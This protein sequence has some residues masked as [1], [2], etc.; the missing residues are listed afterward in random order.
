MS[1]KSSGAGP[2]PDPRGRS[3]SP[4]AS[5]T[6]VGADS[7]HSRRGG[8]GLSGS[9]FHKS[10][11]GSQAWWSVGEF[12]RPGLTHQSVGLT[13]SPDHDDTWDLSDSLADLFKEVNRRE[14]DAGASTS[15]ASNPS[16]GPRQH[17]GQ[18]AGQSRD[19]DDTKHVDVA[20]WIAD[21]TSHGFI[22]VFNSDTD[23]HS[24]LFPCT[25][26]TTAQKICMQIGMPSNSLHVQLNGDIIRRMEP[27]DCPLAVQNEYLAS[28]GYS[29][30]RRIQEEGSTEELSYLVKFYSGKDD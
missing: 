15:D 21:D 30:L 1:V 22:R 27:F 7:F 19:R 24:R 29:D 13:L 8:S 23:E 20:R 3:H 2:V 6:S 26:S 25:L 12:M 9:G 10:Y 16:A 5:H 18:Q 28:I 4:H 17:P 11:Q 14:R